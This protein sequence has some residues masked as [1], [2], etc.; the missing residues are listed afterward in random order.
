MSKSSPKS[1]TGI[2]ASLRPKQPYSSYN[3]FYYLERTY[4]VQANTGTIDK[5]IVDSLDPHHNDPLDFPRPAKYKSTVLP[6]YWY[7]SSHNELFHKKHAHGKMR[8]KGKGKARNSMDLKTMS[9]TIS[10]SWKHARMHD[11]AT[12]DYCEMLAD[13]ELKKF[14]EKMDELKRQKYSPTSTEVLRTEVSTRPSNYEPLFRIAEGALISPTG[15]DLNSVDAPSV[16]WWFPQT[17]EHSMYW[18]GGI[19]SESTQQMA[20]IESSQSHPTRK[21]NYLTW[22][23]ESRVLNGGTGSGV[24]WGTFTSGVMSEH[25]DGVFNASASATERMMLRLQNQC[26]DALRP[27]AYASPPKGSLLSPLRG[28]QSSEKCVKQAAHDEGARDSRLSVVPSTAAVRMPRVDTGAFP[29]NEGQQTSDLVP[30]PVSSDALAQQKQPATDHPICLFILSDDA[31]LDP[32][33]SFPRC[34]CIQ[35][36]EKKQDDNTPGRVGQVG[37]CCFY[38]KEICYPSKRETIYD[39]VLNFQQS[40]LATCPNFPETVKVKYNLLI[41][42]EYWSQKKRLS[43]EFLRAYYAEAASEIGLL[44]SP[45]GLIFGAPPNQSGVP[46]TK[47]QALIDAAERR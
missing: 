17:T 18:G 38:C 7:S 14:L 39:N 4:I 19:P 20:G 30:D 26:T 24:G 43:C 6:P 11:R 31:V 34:H 2:D 29:W 12:K 35:L 15:P 45:N 33:H 42:Q 16:H 37:L 5:E 36:F 47:L 13:A 32:V 8:C 22:N 1:T 23:Q 3:I 10:A 46:S 41:Q 25:T 9:K 28:A 27:P 40:H 44:D 21:N